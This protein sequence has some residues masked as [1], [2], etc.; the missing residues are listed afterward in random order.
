MAQK[1]EMNETA[2]CYLSYIAVREQ[3][4]HKAQ[5]VT[6]LIFGEDY[7]VIETQNG[8]EISEEKFGFKVGYPKGK[9]F[10]CPMI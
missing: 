3:P 1:N 5:M 8:S 6:Q 9:Y 4:T 10:I 7:V 2:I